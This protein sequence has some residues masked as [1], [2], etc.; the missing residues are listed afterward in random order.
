MK[1]IRVKKKDEGKWFDSPEFKKLANDMRNAQKT[2]GDG[3]SG[4]FKV[5]FNYYREKDMEITASISGPSVPMYILNS[6]VYSHD[7][8]EN[9]DYAKD[10]ADKLQAQTSNLKKA[11]DYAN[12]MAKKFQQDLNKFPEEIKQ[13]MKW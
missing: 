3:N 6:S 9:M 1:L 10:Y 8:K 2:F 13:Q 12:K 7:L 4:E 11:V 5:E